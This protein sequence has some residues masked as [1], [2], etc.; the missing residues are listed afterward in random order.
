[1]KLLLNEMATV[2][3]GRTRKAEKNTDVRAVNN[4]TLVGLLFQN[5]NYMY[6]GSVITFWV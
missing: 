1:V 3:K 2:R 5:R 4:V 6:S